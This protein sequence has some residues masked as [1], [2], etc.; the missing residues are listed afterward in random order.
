VFNKIEKVLW[1]RRIGSS[2]C[3]MGLTCAKEYKHA[4]SGQFVMIGMVSQKT[5]LLRRPFSIHNL[6]YANGSVK[7]IEIL[8]KIVGEST[9]NLSNAKENDG[10]KVLGPL[11][12]GFYVPDNIR[13]IGIVAGGVGV[14]PMLFLVSSLQAE[15]FDLSDSTLFLGGKNKADLLCR[16]PFADFGI[17]VEVATDDGSEGKKGLVT[18]LLDLS[19][20]KG[21]IFD[22]LLA[23]GPVPMLKSV[24]KLSETHHISCQ[25]SIETIMACG[26]GVCL[27]CAVKSNDI[28]ARYLHTCVDGPVFNSRIIKL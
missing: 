10:I 16:K 8:Y 4:K 21:K 6:I 25:V 12:K 14:A 11:G 23:C 28:A 15:G 20:A 3:H 5:P 22:I 26:M 27:G 24:A 1:N 18:D 13:R 7:G 19:F 9:K 2:Y 17:K